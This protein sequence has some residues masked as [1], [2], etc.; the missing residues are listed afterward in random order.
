MQHVKRAICTHL[1]K[2]RAAPDLAGEQVGLEA[3]TARTVAL[4]LIDAAS[5]AREGAAQIGSER[6]VALNHIDQAIAEEFTVDN[7]G[8]VTSPP[9][10][11]WMVLM[12]GGD[13]LLAQAALDK[14]AKELEGDIS[15]ALDAV[16]VADDSA[17]AGISAVFEELP[18][19]DG[20]RLRG[21]H[22]P[23]RQGLSTSTA[24][25]PR[26]RA[27]SAHGRR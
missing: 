23:I 6:D 24:S 9:A 16:G 3:A 27:S 26:L 15:R 25:P 12:F 13:S 10:F 11:D 17:A 8:S 1:D 14:R 5:A 22:R 19:P 2:Y 18:H 4:V 7:D 20:S 21:Q